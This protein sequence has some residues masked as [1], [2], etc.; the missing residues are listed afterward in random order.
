MKKTILF[1]FW[2][3]ISTIIFSQKNNT[4]TYQNYFQQEVNYDIEV[5][6]DDKNHILK[7]V[8]NIEYI[9]NSPDEL[10][11]IYFHLWANAYKNQRT[12]FAKQKIQ[13]GATDFFFAKKEE[14]GGYTQIDFS[15]NNESANWS[16]DEKNIDIVLLKLNKTLLPSQSIQIRVPFEIKIPKYFSRMGHRHQAYYMAQWYPKPAVYDRTGWH[17]MPYLEYGEYYSEF[18]KYDVKIT[19]PKNYVVAATGDLQTETEKA[20]LIKRVRATNK[21][22]AKNYPV[23]LK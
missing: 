22:A 14:M 13:S 2:S 16:Y 3:A 11:E 1:F 7:G 8:A 10:N 4:T 9:N 19:L 20:F 12:A 6:L 23:G 21:F 15:I 17:P 5:T 18:G